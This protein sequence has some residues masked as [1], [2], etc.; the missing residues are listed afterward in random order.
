MTIPIPR[1]LPDSYA[2][3]TPER[4]R[5]WG[6]S[7]VLSDLDNTLAKYS[8]PLPPPGAVEWVG[9]LKAA[10][11]PVGIVSNNRDPERVRAHAQ[12]LDVPYVCPARKPRPD[13]LLA[14][15]ATLGATPSETAVVGDQIFT[16]AAAAVRAGMVPIRV[17]SLSKSLLVLLRSLVEWPFILASKRRG[18]RL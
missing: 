3:I 13:A 9:A 1:Y 6:V 15:A 8:D 14:L 2:A 10:G 5:R 12:A 16:D 17:P 18:G 11:I 7:A 4:L